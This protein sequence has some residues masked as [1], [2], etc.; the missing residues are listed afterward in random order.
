MIGVEYERGG[1]AEQGAEGGES[2][3]APIEAED[4]EP[5]SIRDRE[6]GNEY[7][8]GPTYIKCQK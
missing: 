3:A 1:D 8:L 5:F 7:E 6:E 2:G 4:R